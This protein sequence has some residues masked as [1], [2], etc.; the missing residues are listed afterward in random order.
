MPSNFETC[1]EQ[2]RLER[3]PSH[4]T[5][6]EDHHYDGC[7]EGSEKKMEIDFIPMD[8]S[9]VE[10]VPKDG[11]LRTYNRAF[12]SEIIALLN[13]SILL[14]DAMERFDAYLISES[15][16]FVYNDRIIILTCGTTLLL[17]TLPAFIDA[18]AQ[19]GLEVAWFQYSRKNFLFP[20]KQ[21]SPHKTFDMEVDYLERIFPTGRPFVMGPMSSDHWYL[22]V[23]DFID[24]GEGKGAERRAHRE[25]MIAF[26]KRD[27][28]DGKVMDKDQMLNVYMYGID[29]HVAQLFVRGDALILPS[30]FANNNCPDIGSSSTSCSSLSSSPNSSVPA[31]KAN[32]DAGNTHNKKQLDDSD[33]NAAAFEGFDFCT[34]ADEAT[35]RSGIG[36]L[37]GNDG[38]VA[39]AHLFEPCGYS[40][41]GEADNG[42]AYWTIHIT[43]EA[44]CSYASFETNYNCKS[45]HPLIE[46][47]ISLFR[48]AKF[49]TVEHVDQDSMIGTAGPV[50]AASVDGYKATGR[51]LTEFGCKDYVVQMCNYESRT[52]KY[53]A[54]VP[55]MGK[56]FSGSSSTAAGR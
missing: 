1:F 29:P 5:D 53:V 54:P 49:T 12:W 9:D 39:H 38:S 30:I 42:Q 37:L 40:M 19:I 3:A 8:G 47:I 45:Y 4:A 27:G 10:R 56:I 18:A 16:L 22:F 17:K 20:D 48:P 24:R 25:G 7:F 51:T 15:S 21:H 11:G 41:N 43:P 31:I 44:S 46:H 34:S 26:D 36:G 52:A 28:K 23:A 2:A 14:H 50:T 35:A 55:P 32:N 6:D 33:L 13:G